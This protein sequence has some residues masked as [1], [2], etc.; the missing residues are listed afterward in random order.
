MHACIHTYIHTYIHTRIYTCMHEYMRTYI[1]TYTHTHTYINYSKTF[2][3]SIHSKKIVSTQQFYSASGCTSSDLS[4][5][6]ESESLSLL[7]MLTEDSLLL[8]SVANVISQQL[9]VLTINKKAS[10]PAISISNKC[11]YLFPYFPSLKSR[12]ATEWTVAA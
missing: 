5:R 6:S 11:R 10:S 1:H 9:Y 2:D 7:L 8:L 4:V 3:A 12:L